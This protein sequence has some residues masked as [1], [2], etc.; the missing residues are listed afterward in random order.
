[1][2]FL[3]LGMPTSCLIN[4]YGCQLVGF[5]GG[6]IAACGLVASS[7]SSDIWSFL[8]TFGVIG[9]KLYLFYTFQYTYIYQLN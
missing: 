8:P 7:M 2:L 1:M 9:G 4:K 3:I 5:T 6:L